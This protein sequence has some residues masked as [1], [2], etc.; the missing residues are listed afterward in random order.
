MKK[1]LF[2]AALFCGAFSLVLVSS[3]FKPMQTTM[4]ESEDPVQCAGDPCVDENGNI[5][6]TWKK[7]LGPKIC[8]GKA[9]DD[10][11]HQEG[12]V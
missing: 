8:C 7:F 10:R 12:L 11:G 4:L 5:Y 9:D 6:N 3:G 2:R 1:K